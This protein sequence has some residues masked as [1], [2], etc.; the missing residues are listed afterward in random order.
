MSQ[1]NRSESARLNGA[2]SKGPVTAEGKAKSSRNAMKHGLNSRLVVLENEDPEEFAKL[3]AGYFQSWRPTTAAQAQLVEELAA[4]SWRQK[5]V[6][7]L[8]TELFDEQLSS[9]ECADFAVAK[10]FKQLCDD[11]RMSLL[12]RYQGQLSRLFDRVFKELMILQKAQRNE[13][14]LPAVGPGFQPEADL[15]VGKNTPTNPTPPVEVMR[16]A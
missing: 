6:T 15:L 10:A 1:L 16:A 11:G 14:N 3:R 4:T 8:E 5:R 7:Q 12:L 2:K 9:L 13:P